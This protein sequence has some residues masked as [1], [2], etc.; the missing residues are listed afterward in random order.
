[1]P[2]KLKESQ[3]QFTFRQVSTIETVLI[4]IFL[5]VFAWGTGRDVA[6]YI[7]QGQIAKLEQALASK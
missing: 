4:V 6:E 7:E 1:M 5:W 3:D 2:N